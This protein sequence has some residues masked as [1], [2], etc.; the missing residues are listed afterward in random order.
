M[1]DTPI[2]TALLYNIVHIATLGYASL[3]PEALNLVQKFIIIEL[4]LLGI[5]SFALGETVLITATAIKK[6]ILIA[7]YI[8][9]IKNFGWL[10]QILFKSFAKAGILAGNSEITLDDLFDPSAILEMGFDQIGNFLFSESIEWVNLVYT[11]PMLIKEIISI[12]ILVAYF[13]M[14]LMNFII[15]LEFYI[16]TVC[17]VMLLPFGLFRP[18][19]F[20]AE[21]A[22]AATFRLGVKFMVFSFIL[23][24]TFS[25]L[26]DLGL[27]STPS[28]KEM[29]IAL[30]TAI[31]IV[32]MAGKIPTLASNLISGTPNLSGPTG[33]K[34][35]VG[36]ISTAASAAFLGGKAVSISKTTALKRAAT[37]GA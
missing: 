1:E 8:Y 6:L 32:W 24:M 29:I 25:I 3:V 15:I 7:F 31:T 21:G 19:A 22:I 37:K 2:F 26:S 5:F 33:H 36:G 28:I 9:L 10:S 20:L 35:L 23:C 12:F 11:L 16:F 17:A 14:A 4:I 30:F 27:S 34:I 13:I 18:T